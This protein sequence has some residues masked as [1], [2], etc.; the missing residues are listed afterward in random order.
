VTEQEWY[1]ED[2]SKAHGG[3]PWPQE[4]PAHIEVG[5]WAKLLFVL[6]EPDEDGMEGE[7][8]WVKIT[9]YADGRY[10]GEL[11]SD[12]TIVPLEAGDQITF[13]NRHIRDFIPAD[14]KH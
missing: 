12:P 14:A 7:A 6:N 4:W 5:A 2:I 10:T 9:T 3:Q 11:D 1:L 8:M 13:E